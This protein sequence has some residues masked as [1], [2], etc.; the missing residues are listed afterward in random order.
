MGTCRTTQ[1]L[2][3]FPYWSRRENKSPGRHEKYLGIINYFPIIFASRCRVRGNVLTNVHE[4]VY[5]G[6]QGPSGPSWD[7]TPGRLEWHVYKSR[8][9]FWPIIEVIRE[10]ACKNGGKGTM[11]WIRVAARC[12]VYAIHGYTRSIGKTQPVQNGYTFVYIFF[13]FVYTRFTKI[14]VRKSRPKTYNTGPG[15]RSLA[16]PF[17][18][19]PTVMTARIRNCTTTRW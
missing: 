15:N 19:P 14:L 7:R 16:P 6:D 12:N 17:W 3:D 13:F 8:A 10:E 5:R 2:T 9:D 11:R 4:V 1:T 18:V